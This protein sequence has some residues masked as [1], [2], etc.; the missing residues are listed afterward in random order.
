MT[1]LP[2]SLTLLKLRRANLTQAEI[3]ARYGVTGAAVGKA[4]RELK[5]ATRGK[6]GPLTTTLPWALSDRPDRKAL[7]RQ[8]SFKGLRALIHLRNGERL[9]GG[10]W[11]ALG[12]FARHLDSG[13]VLELP[14]GP[15]TRFRYVPCT[16]ADGTL[17]IR[18]PE[19]S[20][21]TPA[22]EALLTLPT[23]AERRALDLS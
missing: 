1:S 4:L 6:E 18:W 14:E 7:Y 2:D 15:G 5:V 8:N 21:P 3:G 23:A 19:G 22:Q 11:T 20:R 16:E 17:A 12:E 13:E 10:Y 9:S